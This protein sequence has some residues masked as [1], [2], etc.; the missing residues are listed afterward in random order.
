MNLKNIARDSYWMT[1]LKSADSIAWTTT[2]GNMATSGT[3]NADVAS[4]QTS[5][6]S[7]GSGIFGVGVL[8]DPPESEYV[9]YRVKAYMPTVDHMLLQMGY[10]PA[11]PTGDDVVAEVKY[12]HLVGE[13]DEIIMFPPLE[14]TD[15]YYGRALMIGLASSSVVSSLCHL[16]VQKLD[17]SPPQFGVA[18]P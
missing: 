10:A 6:S 13:L 1:S 16:S 4:V 17:V 9:P 5:G 15:T 2:S 7:G 11:T 12:F 18:V 3:V 8:M 14:T